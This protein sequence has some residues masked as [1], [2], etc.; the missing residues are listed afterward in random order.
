MGVY[1]TIIGKEQLFAPVVTL[2]TF[3]GIITFFFFCCLSWLGLGDIFEP[4]QLL[5]NT[6]QFYKD[7]WDPEK[8]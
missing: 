1:G 7:S 6:W 2:F 3:Y 4:K 5:K 8:R